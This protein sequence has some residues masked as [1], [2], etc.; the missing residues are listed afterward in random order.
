MSKRNNLHESC[1][2]PKRNGVWEGKTIKHSEISW[3]GFLK[4]VI[5][6]QVCNRFNRFNQFKL[7]TLRPRCWNCLAIAGWGRCPPREFWTGGAVAQGIWWW[8][9][10]GR[11]QLGLSG[12]RMENQVIAKGVS[13]GMREQQ[14]RGIFGSFMTRLLE[15]GLIQKKGFFRLCG[16]GTSMSRPLLQRLLWCLAQI[17][18]LTKIRNTVKSV[19]GPCSILR[20][21]NH[22]F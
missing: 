10:K 12:K 3:E 8:E 16:H 21:G 6:F 22:S 5:I 20:P 2:V 19:W 11:K 15:H 9:G 1:V 14:V 17:S 13:Q 18:P 7:S 4:E